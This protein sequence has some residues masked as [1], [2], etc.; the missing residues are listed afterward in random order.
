MTS[1]R[2]VLVGALW[3]VLVA[4]GS[5]KKSTAGRPGAPAGSGGIGGG[6]G[7]AGG[8]AG[9]GAGATGGGGASGGSS[10]ATSGGGG[11][12]GRA[13]T[14][15]VGGSAGSGGDAGGASAAGGASDGGE[16]GEATSGASGAGGEGGAGTLGEEVLGIYTFDDA[17]SS[18]TCDSVNMSVR[19]GYV[20]THLVVARTVVP[21][22][23]GDRPAVVVTGCSGVAACRTLASALAGDYTAYETLPYYLFSSADTDGTLTNTVVYFGT[24]D[25]MTCRNGGIDGVVL[26]LAGA[27]LTLEIRTQRT[28]YPAVSGTCPAG[29]AAQQGAAAACTQLRVMT[30]TR[31]E[32]L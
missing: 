12:A 4:C 24:L 27:A 28:D 26:S 30:G 23:T 15:G 20:A 19:G 8:N 31:V 2:W 32:A 9:T 10:G 11:G 25:G 3:L 13:G 14:G 21:G 1:L 7:G 17:T 29:V 5:S 16:A 18:A 6:R 22:S